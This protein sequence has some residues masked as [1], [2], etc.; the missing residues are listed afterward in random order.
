L[1]AVGGLCGLVLAV[2]VVLN[3]HILVG[4][5]EG[6]AATPRE[7]WDDSVGLAV[8]DVALLMAGPLLGALTLRKLLRRPT[9]KPPASS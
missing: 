2:I 6:Y 8:V 9:P 7:V 5:E 1:A 4:L 3:L